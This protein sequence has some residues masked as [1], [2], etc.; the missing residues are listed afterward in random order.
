MGPPEKYMAARLQ[1]Q[2]PRLIYVCAALCGQIG[3][4]EEVAVPGLPRI[5]PPLVSWNRAAVE[6]QVR[7]G[8]GE[9]APGAGHA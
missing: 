8:S 2:S 7:G 4:E 6:V 9:P 3:K 5:S 1:S